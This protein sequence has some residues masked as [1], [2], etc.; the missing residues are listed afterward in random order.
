MA[1][2]APRGALL[3]SLSP[4][5]PMPVARRVSLEVIVTATQALPE[6]PGLAKA[7]GPLGVW[8]AS[9]GCFASSRSIGDGSGPNPVWPGELP[10]WRPRPLGCSGGFWQWASPAS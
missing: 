3:Q 1:R 5:M 7:I 9:H 6:A 4:Q 10:R 8:I 2:V